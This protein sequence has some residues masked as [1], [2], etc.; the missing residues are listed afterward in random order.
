[1]TPGLGG[2]CSR[3]DCG[4][5]NHLASAR[6]ITWLRP[7]KSPGFAKNA[8]ND[9][10]LRTVIARRSWPKQSPSHPGRIRSVRRLRSREHTWTRPGTERRIQ[11]SSGLNPVQFWIAHND[12]GLPF[13]LKSIIIVLLLR[14][15]SFYPYRLVKIR[16]FV[17]KADLFF[18][19]H[20][21]R[22]SHHP[23][24]LLEDSYA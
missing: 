23:S 16:A 17:P 12:G 7:G 3:G 6:E 14:N 9:S 8:R 20:L 18:N 13:G 2:S 11:L 22:F 19:P 10:P 1:M 15:C 4:Q 5:G 21:P 24:L